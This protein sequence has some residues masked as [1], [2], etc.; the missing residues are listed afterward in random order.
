ML[1]PGPKGRAPEEPD[2]TI[3]W[4][5]EG[6]RTAA[7]TSPD[8]PITMRLWIS[9]ELTQTRHAF[10]RRAEITVEEVARNQEQHYRHSC[11]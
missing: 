1:M 9:P 6:G 4:H 8:H 3:R 5:Q 11:P 10:S 2:E 7:L